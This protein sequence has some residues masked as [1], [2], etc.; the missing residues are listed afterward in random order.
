MTWSGKDEGRSGELVWPGGATP[1]KNEETPQHTIKHIHV[2]LLSDHEPFAVGSFKQ[3]KC[4]SEV[5]AFLLK[6]VSLSIFYLLDSL[7]N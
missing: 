3:F 7:Q 1:K 5:A 6:Y 2:V 4:R